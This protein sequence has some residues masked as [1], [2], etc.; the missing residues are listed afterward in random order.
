M[1][2][3]Y[4]ILNKVFN[5]Q[6][7]HNLINGKFNSVF[8]LCIDDYTDGN[9]NEKY[10]ILIS[11]LYKYLTKNYRNE[12]F[13]KNTLMNNRLLG[14]HS[15]NT[16]TALAEL[17]VGKSIADMV[18]VNGHAT[19]YEI[20]TDL[21]NIS[22]LRRQISDYYKVFNNVCVLTSET[23]VDYL[24]EILKDTSVGVSVLT[25]RN[26]ISYRKPTIENNNYLNQ[27][28]MFKVLRKKEYETIIKSYYGFLPETTQVKY[29]QKCLELFRKIELEEAYKLML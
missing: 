21:D 20:K 6:I 3:N 8:E 9:T 15:L 11:K 12:Y 26:Y 19:V 24:L 7:F 25:N 29:Y 2:R 17:P 14:R 10:H 23:N 4:I 22:R 13:Y 28:S 18:L 27:I 16:T 5:Q 1:E